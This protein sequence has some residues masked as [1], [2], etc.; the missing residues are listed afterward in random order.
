MEPPTHLKNINPEFFL[1]KGDAGTRSGAE[2]EG[3]SIQGLPH[4]G[5]HP[6]C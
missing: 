3:K 2:I 4:L 6:I 1:S 5:I